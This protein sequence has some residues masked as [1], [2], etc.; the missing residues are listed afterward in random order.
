M[1][2][3]PKELKSVK[4]YKKD[5]RNLMIHSTKILYLKGLNDGEV[6]KFDGINELEIS[7]RL[8]G[9]YLLKK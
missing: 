2:L 7:V 3:I 5:E 9:K 8:R 1:P 4:E 6:E